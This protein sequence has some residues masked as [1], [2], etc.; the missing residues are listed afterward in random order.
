[1]FLLF[2]NNFIVSTANLP[3]SFVLTI[4]NDI[5]TKYIQKYYLINH[6]YNTIKN[7]LIILKY[8]Y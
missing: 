1:M 4:D 5:S 7:D 2:L 3:L 8:I 6:I